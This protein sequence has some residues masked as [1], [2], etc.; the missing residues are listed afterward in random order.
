MLKDLRV[1][2]SISTLAATLTFIYCT[3]PGVHAQTV[4]IDPGTT[5]QP[6]RGF[7]GH[8][9]AGWIPDLTSA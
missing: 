8:S 4:T 2:P 6:I 5:Y 3:A 1:R 9:G 7:G